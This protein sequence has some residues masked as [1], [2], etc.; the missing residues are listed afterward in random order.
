LREPEA[1]VKE[2][3]QRYEALE[4]LREGV[5]REVRGLSPAQRTFQPAPD[6][7]SAVQVIQHLLLA[8]RESVRFLKS[9]REPGRRSFKHRILHVGVRLVL[10]SGLRVKAPSERVLP[11]EDLSLEELEAAW[12]ETRQELLE[13]LGG[14]PADRLK[15]QVFRHPIA[16]PL[17][18][19]QALDFF[20]NHL[21]HHRRQLARIQAAPGFSSV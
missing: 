8:E 20:S 12:Q 6:A 15:R 18:I 21:R 2:L 17:D 11:Q 1:V 10:A 19:E 7:W 4:E 9:G 14:V 13:Y 16:G 5:L 3:Q